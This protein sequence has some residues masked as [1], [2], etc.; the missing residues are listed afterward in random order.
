M[1][2]VLPPLLRL[3]PRLRIQRFLCATL[4]GSLQGNPVFS[5]AP[6]LRE[7]RRASQ[8]GNP[9]VTRPASPREVLQL[10]PSV[11]LNIQRESPVESALLRRLRCR[12]SSRSL[13]RIRGEAG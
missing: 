7:S 13:M 6:S 8:W 4:R 11:T 10:K 1:P 9:V 2:R 5:R 3:Q 12:Q